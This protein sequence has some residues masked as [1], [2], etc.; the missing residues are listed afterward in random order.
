MDAETKT[1]EVTDTKHTRPVEG[2]LDVSHDT[3]L[4]G[5]VS[6]SR[7]VIC[8][9]LTLLQFTLIPINHRVCKYPVVVVYHAVLKNVQNGQCV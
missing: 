2:R 3:A 7:Y 5:A 8:N 6:D 1:V 4:A 9:V